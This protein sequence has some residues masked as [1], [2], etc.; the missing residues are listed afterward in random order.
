MIQVIQY[1]E[2]HGEQRTKPTERAKWNQII[3]WQTDIQVYQH[4]HSILLF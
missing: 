1:K 2:D 4:V 3:R